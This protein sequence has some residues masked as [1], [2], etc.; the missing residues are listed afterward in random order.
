MGSLI[1]IIV[2]DCF[3]YCL[4]YLDTLPPVT[5]VGLG[6]PVTLTCVL[7]DIKSQIVFWYKQSAGERLKL[8]VTLGGN[9]KPLFETEFSSSL[10]DANISENMS[11]LTILTT[12][13][14]DEGMYHCAAL[15]WPKI[16]WSGTYVS[17]KG[18]TERTTELRVVQEPTVSDQLRPG[19]LMSLQC[20][21]LSDPDSKTC[22]GGHSVLWFRAGSH[23]SRPDIIYTAGNRRDGCEERSASQKSCVHHFSKNISSSDAGT[24]YC[25]VDTCGRLLFGDGT[26]VDVAQSTHFGFIIMVILIVCLVISTVGN[27]FLLCKQKA[28][29]Q[30]GGLESA[31]SEARK[32]N[33][34]R[35]EHN[36]ADAENKLNYAALNFSARKPRGRK[37]REFSE[38][39]VYAQVKL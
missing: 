28:R 2:V 1:V 27:V 3:N 21:V 20:S 22:P 36:T 11:N 30:H 5:T 32:D 38:D 10:F 15:E 25:A 35:Q 39:S 31:V 37:K 19:D 6:E 13:Q 7:P 8:M 29:K 26:K 4:F 17:L 23:E 24:Y 16:S 33:A 9:G 14:E 34:S 12:T 18:N